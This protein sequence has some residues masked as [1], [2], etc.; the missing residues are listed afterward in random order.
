M[1]RG[2]ESIVAIIHKRYNKCRADVVFARDFA[3]NDCIMRRKRK[4]R[5]NK[6]KQ[7]KERFRRVAAEQTFVQRNAQRYT[8]EMHNRDVLKQAALARYAEALSTPSLED[9]MLIEAALASKR[10]LDK[11]V[12]NISP[13]DTKKIFERV[14]NDISERL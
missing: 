6:R 14:L 7:E 11:L 1:Q 5:R 3:Q 13:S 9:D 2:T 8:Q 4:N 12:Y 10:S